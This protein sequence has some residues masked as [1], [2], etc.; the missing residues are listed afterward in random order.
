MAYNEI[1][2][3]RIRAAV[4]I[5]PKSIATNIHEKK[6]F[7]GL[8]Y[9]YKGKMTVGILQNDL[10]VRVKEEYMDVSLNNPYVRPMEFTGKPMKEF[11]FVSPEGYKTELQLQQWIEHGLSHARQ[12][13]NE[14]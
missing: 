4:S 3:Y 1:L 5:L 8:A 11:I 12:K 13:L 14:V 2:A 9:L 10:M 6:M 7:G